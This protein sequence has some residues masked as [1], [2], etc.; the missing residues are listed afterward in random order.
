MDQQTLN[1]LLDNSQNQQQELISQFI[2]KLQPQLQ[3]LV[4]VSIVLSV[5]MAILVLVNSIYKWRVERAILR[6]DKNVQALAEH[7]VGLSANEKTNAKSSN[8]NI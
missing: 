7:H 6:I 8:E 4:T 2:D 5:F 1:S 3:V